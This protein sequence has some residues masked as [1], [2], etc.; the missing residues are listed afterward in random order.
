MGSSP[1]SDEQKGGQVNWKGRD[2]SAKGYEEDKPGR[3]SRH[4]AAIFHPH[5]ESNP[6]ILFKN[7][8]PGV[9]IVVQQ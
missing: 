7:L 9:P 1:E 2:V 3:C 6:S 5:R 8:F 4:S